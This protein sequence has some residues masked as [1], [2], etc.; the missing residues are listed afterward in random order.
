MRMSRGPTQIIVV[1]VYANP[2]AKPHNQPCP[3]MPHA[4]AL[5][6]PI[7]V[8]P[9]SSERR[10]P[11]VL[12]EMCLHQSSQSPS[13]LSRA[14]PR[15]IAVESM[16][17]V[18]SRGGWT[19]GV[20]RF[21]S[22]SQWKTNRGGVSPHSTSVNGFPLCCIGTRTPLRPRWF[23][24]R[25]PRNVWCYNGRSGFMHRAHRAGAQ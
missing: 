18:S 14:T 2:R 13:I 9:Q 4:H 1:G 11:I 5:I 25:V 3:Q 19:L 16:H 12:C 8:I 7:K 22:I 15:Y 21:G 24:T 6:Y 23:E 10:V 17:F 20:T